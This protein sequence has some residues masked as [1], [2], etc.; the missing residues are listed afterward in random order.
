[1]ARRIRSIKPEILDD[2]KTAFLSHLEYRLFVGSW[3]VADDHGNLRGEPEYLRGQIVW[4]SSES[5]ETVARALESLVRV[6]LLTPY[7][8]RG[9]S[10]FHVTTWDKHQRIDKPSKAA[11]PGPGQADPLADQTV[12]CISRDSRDT[13]AN[14]REIL[15]P[16]TDQDQEGEEEGEQD[17]PP[18]ASKRNRAHRLAPD[19]MPERG[20]ANVRAEQAAKARGVDLHEELAKLRDWA[21]GVN[22]RRADWDAVWRNWTRNARPKQRSTG[23]QGVLEMQRERIA[24]LEREEQE[25]GMK[26][27]DA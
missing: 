20:D 6:G 16:D 2:T 23:H 5:R 13:L 4:A 11:M 10:Y 12:T 9:Q 22:A 15:L 17:L 26:A 18:K 1:V 7:T 27:G 3:I 21:N 8:V 25:Q 14:A 19:W 24:M